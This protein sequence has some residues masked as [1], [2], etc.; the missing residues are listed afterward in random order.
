[1]FLADGG[2]IFVSAT[3]SASEQIA[4]SALGALAPKDFEMI[5]GGPRIDW[6]SQNCTRTPVTN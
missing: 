2:N 3:T 6:H 5:D 4:G 1:M